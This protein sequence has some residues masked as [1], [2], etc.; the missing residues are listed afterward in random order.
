MI[1]YTVA[2][3]LKYVCHVLKKFPGDWH[4]RAPQYIMYNG[5]LLSQQ[6]TFSK[7]L[8]QYSLLLLYLQTSINSPNFKNGHALVLVNY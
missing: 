6:P 7:L 4:H 1:K 2:M 8:Q 3:V 5:R